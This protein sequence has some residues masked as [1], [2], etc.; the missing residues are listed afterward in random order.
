M[1]SDPKDLP[2]NWFKKL[3]FKKMSSAKNVK[4][5]HWLEMKPIEILN[6][7]KDEVAELEFEIVHGNLSKKKINECV[8]VANFACMLA[9]KISEELK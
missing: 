6:R 9:H 7:L 1:M 3:Q 8:D 2:L 4:K 5:T